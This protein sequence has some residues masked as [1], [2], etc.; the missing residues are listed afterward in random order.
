M[1]SF[2]VLVLHIGCCV[3]RSRFALG[4][5]SLEQAAL[6]AVM[7]FTNRL[8]LREQVC[9]VTSASSVDHG[10]SCRLRVVRSGDVDLDRVGLLVT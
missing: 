3:D 4:L 5:I 1:R 2:T 10:C 8:G 6:L 7:G 9:I